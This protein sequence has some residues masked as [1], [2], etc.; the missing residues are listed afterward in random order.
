LVLANLPERKVEQVPFQS[1]LGRVLAES[2]T[3]TSY[4][5]PFRRSA[6]DG[7]AVRAADIQTAP[8][9]SKLPGRSA[10][11]EGAPAC[12]TPDRPSPS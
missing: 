10:L 5:P 1:A 7:Y 8:S 6:M 11:V 4:V 3:A 2:L 9:T 12:F